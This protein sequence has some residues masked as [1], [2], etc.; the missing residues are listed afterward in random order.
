MSG[1]SPRTSQAKKEPKLTIKEK[2]ELKREKAQATVVKPRK[3]R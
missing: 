3:S 1:K 2:R